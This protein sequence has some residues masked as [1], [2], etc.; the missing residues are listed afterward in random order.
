MIGDR[1]DVTTNSSQIVQQQ[2]LPRHK[3]AFRLLHYPSNIA[4]IPATKKK[5]RYG[6]KVV[7]SSR[8]AKPSPFLP[9]VISVSVLHLHSRNCG[10]NQS[11]WIPTSSTCRD[12]FAATGGLRNYS[13]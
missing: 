1:D 6:K 8:S 3:S 9:P 2:Q 13:R 5:K 12:Y 7:P 4:F 10:F 11:N